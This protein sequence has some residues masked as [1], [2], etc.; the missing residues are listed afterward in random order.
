MARRDSRNRIISRRRDQGV[1]E[2]EPV[3]VKWLV[4]VSRTIQRFA[5]H[6]KK[7]TCEG[8]SSLVRR[9]VRSLPEFLKWEEGED[10]D[11]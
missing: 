8:Q 7:R 3:S 6:H 10:D 5:R 2:K 1:E 9:G 11:E 4:R